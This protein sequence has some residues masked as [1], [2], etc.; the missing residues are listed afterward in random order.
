MPP[1]KGRGGTTL[2]CTLPG[3]DMSPEHARPRG[4]EGD[5]RG[6]V[7]A[8]AHGGLYLG[9]RPLSL[10]SAPSEPLP[11]ARAASLGLGLLRNA[12][13]PPARPPAPPRTQQALEAEQDRAGRGSPP[14]A[15]CRWALSSPAVQPGPPPLAGCPD[16]ARSASR[17][18]SAT[19]NQRRA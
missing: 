4:P 15:S 7:P 3:N 2:P 13:R 16:P 8:K 10:G 12:A 17:S 18:S 6:G 9:L 1:L 14:R 19:A 5:Q 11:L